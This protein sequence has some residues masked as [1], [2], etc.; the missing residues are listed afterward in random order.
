[1]SSFDEF[2]RRKDVRME[3]FGLFLLNAALSVSTKNRWENYLIAT[4]VNNNF[5]QF[6]QI[7]LI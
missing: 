2:R 7:I 3:T 1:M 5:E 4:N 6:L